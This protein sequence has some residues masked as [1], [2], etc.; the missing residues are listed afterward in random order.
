[1][2][3]DK[4]G[5]LNLLLIEDDAG[6]VELIT[7]NLEELGFSVMSAV[8]GVEALAH[9]KKQTPDLM[10]LDYSLPDINGKEL[11]ETLIKQQTPPPPFIITTGQGNERIAVDM[12][13]LGAMDYLT[14]DILFLEKLP[15]VVKRVVKEIESEGKLRQAEDALKESEEQYRAVV[16]N[17]GDYIMRYDKKFKH[18]YANKLALEATGLPMD[19]YIGKTHREL[20]FPDHLCELWEKNIKLVFDTGKQQNIEFDVELAEGKMDLELQL[21]PE[22]AVD[23]SVKTVI[24]RSRDITSRRQAGIE[25]RKLESQLHQAQKMESIGILAGGIAHDFNNILTAIMG[26]SQLLL[27]EVKKGSTME[28]DINEILTASIRARDL[29]SQVLVFA[30]QSNTEIGPMRVD[31]IATEALQLIRS[32]VPT[33]IKIKSIIESKSRIIG[34]P[35][36]CHQIIMNLCTNAAYAMEKEG[37]ILEI[38]IQDADTNDNAVIVGL[39]L[40]QDDYIKIIVKDTGDGIPPNIIGSIFDPYFTSKPIGEGTGMGLSVVH[41][42]VESYGG[43]ITVNSKPQKGTELTIFIPVTKHDEKRVVESKKEL[44][45][46]TENILVVDDELSITN[47]FDRT[48]RSLGYSV[49]KRNSSIEALE[50]FRSKSNSFDLVITDMAMPNMTGDNL[51]IKMIAIKPTIP[52]I[53]CTGYSKTISDEKAFK[54]GIK[55]FVQK[56]IVNTDLAETI[57]TVLDDANKRA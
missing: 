33:S 25:K 11:I 46:G 41:G 24:G 47:I 44:P 1:M 10:L 48:L 30:R 14:K 13:K 6:L 45:T 43:K 16:D 37:G 5:V 34:N 53:L 20:G 52:I 18:I 49:T 4:R 26:F 31:L 3:T 55:A 21:N 17:I 12:M 42:I 28:D 19:Q 35:I 38:R 22:F 8:S 9:L 27:T 39:G 56:P 51:A 7:S 54:I 32:S 23:G 40:K 57:R 29:I 2:E 36:Q 50:L 15:D